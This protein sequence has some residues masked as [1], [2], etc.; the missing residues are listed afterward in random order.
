MLVEK[1]AALML[2]NQESI[3][4]II[5]KRKFKDNFKKRKFLSSLAN[6]LPLSQ[7]K[8][9]SGKLPIQYETD[10][11]IK[12]FY[13]ELFKPKVRN[14][15]EKD[16]HKKEMHSPLHL[17]KQKYKKKQKEEQQIAP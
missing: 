1:G 2:S 4:H 15:P 9:K 11:E 10:N 14:Q 3:L 8:D 13:L 6:K 5:M 12:A 17:S 16:H 7:V